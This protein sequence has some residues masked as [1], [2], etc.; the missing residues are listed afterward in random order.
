MEKTD[1]LN[2][3]L[4]HYIAIAFNQPKK[5]PRLPF[6]IKETVSTA[7]VMSDDEME[8]M[9]MKNTILAG[10]TIKEP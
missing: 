4:G 9:M 7:D 8:R 5:Y 3:L 10:G 6:L 1:T 2:H